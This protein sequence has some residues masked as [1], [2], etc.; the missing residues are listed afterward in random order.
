MEPTRLTVMRENVGA[1]CGS[2]DLNVLEAFQIK[3]PK[4]KEFNP[5]KAKPIM[6]RER[7]AAG[8]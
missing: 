5:N 1:T 7:K 6:R 8:L 4:I 2:F 3:R